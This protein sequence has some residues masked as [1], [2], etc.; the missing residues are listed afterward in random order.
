MSYEKKRY[1]GA[2]REARDWNVSV[3]VGSQVSVQLDD[4]SVLETKTRSEAWVLG[5]HT[6][7]VLLDG[8]TG[9]YLL[10][11]VRPATR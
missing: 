7:V 5:G 10:S 3:A 2:E 4:G 11:R 6:A 1:A 8:V 9:G